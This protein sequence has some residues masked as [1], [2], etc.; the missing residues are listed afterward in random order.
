M[1]RFDA[2]LRAALIQ[3]LLAQVRGRPTDLLPFDVVRERLPLR[4][5]VDRGIQEVPLERIVGTVQRERDF[6][7]AFLPRDESLRDRWKE[8]EGLAEGAKG[9]PPVEL[10]RVGDTDFVVDGH[11]R[12]SVA[13]A[14]GLQTIEARVKEFATPVTF[15]TD[16][17]I[18]DVV[19]RQGLAGFLET[20][21][22]PAEKPDE[23]RTTEPNGYERLLDHI[24]V[25]R[26]FR[27]VSERRE[28]P[29]PEAVLSWRDAVYRPMTERIE[30]SGILEEFPGR[31][32]ADLYFFVMD[33]LHYLR[34]QYGDVA[35]TRA[36]AHFRLSRRPKGGLVEKLRTWWAR[37]LG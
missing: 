1:T 32:P 35:P 6:N 17:S 30:A 3:D 28:I 22:L 14:H 5:L 29:W 2:A 13:R 33:H 37:L 31:T 19:A 23:F 15:P 18:E 7:R 34:Q 9:F 26:H 36:L 25:H 4:N 11:H 20:T 27:G 10:Y 16:A 24:N 12:V 21:G 8:I